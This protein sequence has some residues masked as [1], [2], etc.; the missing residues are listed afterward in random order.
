MATDD[1]GG[2]VA[3]EMQEPPPAST[4][5]ELVSRGASDRKDDGGDAGSSS[6]VGSRGR[7]RS[8]VVTVQLLWGGRQRDSK[9]SSF[10]ARRA[11]FRVA[12]LAFAVV[13]AVTWASVA[14]GGDDAT[15]SRTARWPVA[16][17]A[18]G[19]LRF[20]IDKCSLDFTR[21]ESGGGDSV[22]VGVRYSP[23]GTEVHYTNGGPSGSDFRVKVLDGRELGSRYLGGYSCAVSVVVPAGAVLP[24]TR[25]F[26]RGHLS[27]TVTS[28]GASWAGSSVVVDVRHARETQAE[29]ELL[30]FEA[31][32]LAL[33]FERGSAL[34]EGRIGAGGVDVDVPRSTGSVMLR[35]SHDV[36]VEYDPS[37]DASRICLTSS[38]TTCAGTVCTLV[39]DAGSPPAN[40]SA[41]PVVAS[42]GNPFLQVM[43][44]RV[45]DEPA[46]FGVGDGYDFVQRTSTLPGSSFSADARV[47][48]SLD[49]QAD[50]IREVAG[51]DVALYRVGGAGSPPVVWTHSEVFAYLVVPES[52]FD[53]V[54]WGLLTPRVRAANVTLAP[55]FCPGLHLLGV[56]PGTATGERYPLYENALALRNEF[57]RVLGGDFEKMVYSAG[58]DVDSWRGD[59]FIFQETVRP[60]DLVVR[61]V[62]LSAERNILA[63]I[64]LGLVVGGLSSL[65]LVYILSIRLPRWARSQLDE[66]GNAYHGDEW[67]ERRAEAMQRAN[68]YLWAEFLTFGLNQVHNYGRIAATVALHLFVVVLPVLPV[69]VG[70][71]IFYADGFS[72]GDS[73]FGAAFFVIFLAACAYVGCSVLVLLLYYLDIHTF[74]PVRLVVRLHFYLTVFVAFFSFVYLVEVVFWVLLGIA[75]KPNIVMPIAAVVLVV[76]ITVAGTVGRVRALYAT[77]R[78]QLNDNAEA[79]EAQ[80]HVARAAAPPR[81]YAVKNIKALALNDVLAIVSQS[82][83]LEVAGE[84]LWEQIVQEIVRLAT[85]LAMLAFLALGF[86]V[87]NTDSAFVSGLTTA[88][89]FLIGGGVNIPLSKSAAA[90]PVEPEKSSFET[91]VRERATQN[92]EAEKKAE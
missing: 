82:E 59:K 79:V 20:D 74:A 36:R 62:R 65:W 31:E 54:S 52:F 24:D 10:Y 88:A 43:A 5:D 25:I 49:A 37:N 27:S 16:A 32:S 66:W 50:L 56:R 34:V 71:G 40:A 18:G 2:D 91:R 78:A 23:A 30:G 14:I 53:I 61:E 87:L 45:A 21:L 28:N 7:R 72:G 41:L 81:T 17:I 6:A 76:G 48:V 70:L 39:Y 67:P 46:E 84:S 44:T 13:G 60:G 89:V 11:V 8:S 92:L 55:S 47:S 85:L 83:I 38:L 57:K 64:V 73:W 75:V 12:L 80:P 86:F 35:L 29:V 58:G 51:A 69:G 9:N 4:E 33:R 22:S 15:E 90:L 77:T 3:I 19:S 1:Q 42:V 68:I 26:V 63:T